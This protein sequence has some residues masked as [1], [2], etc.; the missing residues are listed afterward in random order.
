VKP[1]STFFLIVLATALA[2]AGSEPVRAIVPGDV[3]LFGANTFSS[4]D[5]LDG[6]DG[7]YHVAGN[8]TLMPGA[9]I[10]CNDTGPSTASAC[11]IR[12]LVDGVMEM[13]EGS[14]I[15]AENNLSGGGGGDIAIDVN[16]DSLTLG[17]SAGPTPGAL[18][19]SRKIAGTDIAGAGDIRITVNGC[20]TLAGGIS[21]GAGAMIAADGAGEAGS[22]TLLSCHRIT[23]DG[24]IQSRGLTTTGRGGPIALVA[25]GDVSEGAAGTVSS[26]GG[27]PGADLVHLEGSSIEVGGLVESTG[28]GQQAP[29]GRNLCN[30]PPRAGKPVNST[31]CVELWS[32]GP[33]AIDSA[34]A[35]NGEINADT[36]FSGG[37][38]G[39]GWIDILS[40]GG[41]IA[42]AG[43]AAPPYAVHAN[44]G[45]TNGHGGAISILSEFGKITASGKAIQANDTAAGGKGGRILVEATFSVVGVELG[46]ASLQAEGATRGG[47]GQ[48]GG[49]IEAHAFNGEI[50]GAAPGSLDAKGGPAPGNGKVILSPCGPLDY[51]GSSTPALIYSPICT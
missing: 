29:H 2:A 33:I 40:V 13:K 3:V 44:Q 31:A 8:L 21:V 35:N 16:G 6:P 37:P 51:T 1:K 46:L 26:R 45:L 47:G 36:G 14:A 15:R 17:G 38:Q 28:A 5:A 10:N 27:G 18:I 23:V 42:I 22:I 30:D 25:S 50:T 24:A 11:P 4:L 7:L 19:S 48:A 34:G 32:F 9:S 41:N 49:H 39:S 43:D 20:T 12:I